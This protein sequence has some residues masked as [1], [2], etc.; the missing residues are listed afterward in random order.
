MWK[1]WMKLDFQQFIFIYIVVVVGAFDCF[2]GF[3]DMAMISIDVGYSFC[4][5]KSHALFGLDGVFGYCR[6]LIL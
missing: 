1:K 3:S 4:F 5:I 6:S 2:D